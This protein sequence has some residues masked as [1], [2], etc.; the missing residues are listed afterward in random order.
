TKLLVDDVLTK[1]MIGLFL[2][3]IGVLVASRFVIMG[4]QI[5]RGRNVAYVGMQVTVAIR[6]TL[7]ARLQALSLGFYDRRNVG[8]I[9]SR[10][11][12][13]TGALYDVLIDGIP[14]LLNQAVMLVAIPTAMLLMNW[15][16]ALWAML[17]VPLI[18]LAVRWF[19]KRMMRVWSRFWHSWSRLSGSL[20]GVLQGTRVVKA[21]HGESREEARFARRVG[22]V[23]SMGYAAEGHWATFFPLVMFTMATSGFMVWWVGGQ[24]VLGGVMTIG[25]LTA[26]LG[27]VAMMQQ[28]LMMLQRIVDWTSRSLT[29]AERV[30]EIMDTPVD[31]EDHPD[32]I[33]MPAI[34]GAVRFQDVHFGYDKSREVLHGINLEV[35]RGEMIGLVGASGSGKTTLMNLLLRFYDPTQG[36]IEIDGVDLRRIRLDDLRRQIGVVLQ[37]SYLFPGSV[38]ENI[39]YGRPEASLEEILAAAKAANAH[40]F[41]VNFPDG[42]D[43]YVGE[44]GQRLSGG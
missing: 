22:D 40:D 44:R 28:P 26:F 1:R 29:A 18:L 14:V 5:A 20:N 4:I 7:F 31:V 13:D 9:M 42:Y 21:F 41:V 10:M 39:A 37:D 35:A 34:A 15:R 38:R 16:I 17:P 12:N 32:A 3:L 24:G 33:P 43:A 25:E 23:A 27:Y 8:S 36:V 2:P 19:R 30:F 6:T 11:T